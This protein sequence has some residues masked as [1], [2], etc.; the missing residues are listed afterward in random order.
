MASRLSANEREEMVESFK[1]GK[2]IDEISKYKC[3]KINNFRNSENDRG[4]K[5]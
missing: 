4:K 2:S 3:T 5:I 1:D